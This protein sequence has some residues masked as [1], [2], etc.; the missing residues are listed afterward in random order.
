MPPHSPLPLLGSRNPG[1]RRPPFHL[2]IPCCKRTGTGG[3]SPGPGWG[4][5]GPLRLRAAGCATGGPGRHLP[6]LRKAPD[7]A[8]CGP[9]APDSLYTFYTRTFAPLPGLFGGPF[10]KS[11]LGMPMGCPW[12]MPVHAL[13]RQVPLGGGSSAHLGPGSI[14]YVYMKCPEMQTRITERRK[15]TTGGPGGGK[16]RNFRPL[17]APLAC[18]CRR[19]RSL[20]VRAA[21]PPITGE[22][23]WR[24]EGGPR[25]AEGPGRPGRR[26][27]DTPPWALGRNSRSLLE[28]SPPL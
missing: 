17:G 11:V 8:R 4:R 1:A 9:N 12:P 21:S 6:S 7:G 22:A 18:R 3:A 25:A 14:P 27:P 13:P 2:F 23:L 24:G 19:G 5:K 28:P 16:F 15:G 10:G 26:R 20:S